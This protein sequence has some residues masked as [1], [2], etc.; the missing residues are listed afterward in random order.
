MSIKTIRVKKTKPFHLKDC[1]KIQNALIDK[2]LYA[3]FD[4]CHEMWSMYSEDKY[5]SGWVSMSDMTGQEIC[6]A[7]M[8][9]YEVDQIA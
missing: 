6:D 9:Y 5:A 8:H 1:Q 7:L 4:Q 3:T 2:G